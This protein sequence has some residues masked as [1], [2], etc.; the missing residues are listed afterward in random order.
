MKIKVLFLIQDLGR[1]GAEKVLVNLVNQMDKERFDI[2]VQTLFDVGVNRESLNPEICYIPGYRNEFH[3]N[4]YLIKLLPPCFLYWYIIRD[5]YD[6][7]IS[8]LE[9]SPA[10]II[11]G[12]NNPGIKKLAWIHT[13]FSKKNY[14]IGFWNSHAAMRAY[15]KFDR[16][17]CVSNSVKDSFF[18]WY[19][20]DRVDTVYNTIDVDAI[21]SM[22]KETIDD[23]EFDRKCI[24][25]ISAGKIQK[26]K[27]FDRLAA[28][29]KKLSDE[30]IP[31]HTYLLGTGEEEVALRKYVC[32]NG[33][34]DSFTII[35]FRSNPY[36]YMKNADLYIC[37]SVREGFSTAITEA[38]ILGLPV[39][40]TDCGGAK[41]LLGESNEYGIVTENNE[42]SLYC[43]MKRLLLDRDLFAHY[44][45]QAKIRGKMFSTEK[46]VQQVEQL[47]TDV[48][49]R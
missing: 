22:A 21:E 3:G 43:Q 14:C 39:V 12:C 28:I 4:S 17:V 30:G 31:L 13:T 32:Q 2:S 18:S 40:S 47:I 46:T 20:I 26:V 29:H 5:K 41:E 49:G 25:V 19:P 45:E 36:K 37:S 23:V 27:A 48:C 38:L 7:V 9:G 42:D 15:K 1:G 16:I 34:D 10:R 44:K 11:S 33:I 6:C 24:N 8:Y 35:G